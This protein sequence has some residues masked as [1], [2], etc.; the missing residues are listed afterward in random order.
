MGCVPPGR[1]HRGLLESIE[2]GA[3]RSRAGVHLLRP[4][5][6]SF[7]WWFFLPE[8]EQL[9]ARPT[10]G[11]GSFPAQR[12][13]P[14]PASFGVER[15]YSVTRWRRTARRAKVVRS[16]TT[17]HSCCARRSMSQRTGLVSILVLH[18]AYRPTEKL[19]KGPMPNFG[20]GL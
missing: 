2:D 14:P 8:V 20:L 4:C 18:I 7:P 12:F 5:L 10:R 1:A 11:V 19:T 3:G 16:P 13:R 17:N 15:L 6:G 9:G